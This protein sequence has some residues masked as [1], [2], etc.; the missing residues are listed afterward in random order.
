[1]DHMRIWVTEPPSV[2]L[3]QA[4]KFKK[5]KSYAKEVP[6]QVKSKTDDVINPQ[7]YNFNQF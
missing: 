7:N 5:L 4:K 6:K 2:I 3:S 1:M